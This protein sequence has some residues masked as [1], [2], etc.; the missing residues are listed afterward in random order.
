MR[1]KSLRWIMP[2]ALSGGLLLT[3]ANFS[4]HGWVSGKLQAMGKDH[5]RIKLDG[6]VYIVPKALAKVLANV[7]KGLAHVMLNIDKE[8]HV[9]AIRRPDAVSGSV[10]AVSSTSITVAGTTYAITPQTSVSYGPF[11]LNSSEIPVGSTITMQLN[12]NTVTR[13]FLKTDASLPAG[14]ELQGAITA[15][16]TNT[17][18]VDGYTLTVA[19]SVAVRG[20]V[21]TS[22]SQLTAGTQVSLYLTASG[23]VEVIRV[24]HPEH[25]AGTVS[26]TSASSLTVAGTTYPYAANVRVRYHSYVLTAS[27]IPV[28]STAVAHLNNNGQ[29]SLVWL[30][31]DANLPAS[32]HLSGTISAVSPS[33]IS[34]QGYSLSFASPFDLQFKDA[35]SLNMSVV[36]GD[37]ARVSLNSHGQIQQLEI[38]ADGAAASSGS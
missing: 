35:T 9:I 37:Q 7:K 31:S 20:T 25:V 21:V 19:P 26:A 22:W 16:G 30:K 4:G 3:G 2:V 11:T 5:V 24:K 33:S 27:Q 15:L 23:Q 28:G 8:G 17:I 10:S 36:A 18:T 13:I 29:V 6:H 12:G 32:S 34:L 38:L 14:R 1:T